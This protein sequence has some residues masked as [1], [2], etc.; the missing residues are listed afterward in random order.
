LVQE[1]ARQG[2]V[3]H[4]GHAGVAAW[5]APAQD[6]HRAGVDVQSRVVDAGV[7]VLDRVEDDSPP[8]VAQQVR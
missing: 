7:E 8:A 5:S 4:L 2:H 3:R 6:E 1:L